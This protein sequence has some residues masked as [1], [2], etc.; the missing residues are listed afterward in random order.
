[1]KQGNKQ[2]A[3]KDLETAKQIFQQQGTVIDYEKTQKL[4]KKLQ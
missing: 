4:L 3:I 2:Q 1:M